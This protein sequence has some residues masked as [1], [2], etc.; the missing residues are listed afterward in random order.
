MNSINFLDNMVD[1]TAVLSVFIL[2][3]RHLVHLMLGPVLGVQMMLIV[4]TIAALAGFLF[5]NWNPSR[6]FMGD[7]GS[8][9]LGVYLAYVGI[10][11]FW[12]APSPVTGADEHWRQAIMTLVVFLLPIAATTTV[13]INRIGR[14]RSPFVGGRDH[15][16]H[17]LSYL[18]LSDA[19]VALTFGS[20]RATRVFLNFAVLRFVGVWRNLHTAIFVLYA[21]AGFLLLYLPTRRPRPTPPPEHGH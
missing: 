10:R 2:L 12:N 19:Q 9:F 5:Y 16:T 8:Q 4:N 13:T 21:V 7:T 3:N 18:G 6:M 20:L 15:T 17:H 14:G 11:C 1:I